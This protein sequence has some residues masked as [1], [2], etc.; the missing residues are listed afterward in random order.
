M[1]VQFR[2]YLHHQGKCLFWWFSAILRI[3]EIKSHLLHVKGHVCELAESTCF[4][5]AEG[6]TRLEPSKDSNISHPGVA[7]H[8][9]V[10]FTITQI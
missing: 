4:T 6:T 1:E 9:V 10:C 8:L 7:I 2:K 3:G 5:L